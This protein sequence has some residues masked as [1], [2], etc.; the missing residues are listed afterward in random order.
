VGGVNFAELEISRRASSIL[1]ES[2]F[3]LGNVEA[4]DEVEEPPL[5]ELIA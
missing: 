2:A 1:A 3:V 4:T 5:P